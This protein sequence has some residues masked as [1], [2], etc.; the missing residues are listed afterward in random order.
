MLAVVNAAVA[1]KETDVCAAVLLLLL[2]S[3]LPADASSL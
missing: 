1:A 3:T 2:P